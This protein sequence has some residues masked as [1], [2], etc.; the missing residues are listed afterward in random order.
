MRH[1]IVSAVFAAA[2][3]LAAVAQ[4]AEAPSTDTP[5]IATMDAE[6]A[7]GETTGEVSNGQTFGDW[8]V[9]CEALGVNRTRCMLN[10]TISLRDSNLLLADLLAFWTDEDPQ[11]LLVAQ[12]PVGAHLPSGFALQAEGAPEEDQL[13][14]TWQAC[15]PKICEAVALP[16]Q[17]LLDKLTSAE[18][19]LAGYRPGVAE[20]AAVFPISVKGLTDGLSALKPKA[21]EE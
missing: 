16:G 15:N 4:D 14:F 5:T 20:E 12:V 7:S 10:Q 8:T 11:P 6:A 19:V 3:P 1:V 13:N 21:A 18:R 2:L 9:R 17:E